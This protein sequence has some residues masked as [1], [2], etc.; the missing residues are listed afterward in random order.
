MGQSGFCRGLVTEPATEVLPTSRQGLPGPELL[1]L[2]G[3][4]ISRLAHQALP[5][6]REVLSSLPVGQALEPG[7]VELSVI[8]EALAERPG[9]EVKPQS[10]VVWVEQRREQEAL[11]SLPG[12]LP[13]PLRE[14]VVPSQSRVEQQPVTLPE[15]QVLSSVALV[16]GQV[17]E[18]SSLSLGAHQDRELPGTE[19]L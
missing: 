5:T 2:A 19:Q 10:S 15:V 7:P 4:S 14:L 18:V 6:V 3:L 13:G 8:P 1:E 17:R 16:P 9:P 12:V 11:Y